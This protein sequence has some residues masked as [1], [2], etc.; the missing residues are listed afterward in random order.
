MSM[1]LVGFGSPIGC[2]PGLHFF[3]HWFGATP[4]PRQV[5]NVP[6]KG[7][8]PSKSSRSRSLSSGAMWPLDKF[9]VLGIFTTL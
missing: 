3:P 9:H 2:V 8:C 1:S 4:V 7:V 6:E 5:R